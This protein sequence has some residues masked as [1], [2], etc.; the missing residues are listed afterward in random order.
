LPYALLQYCHQ[1]SI[2]RCFHATSNKERIVLIAG[3][4]G[5]PEFFGTIFIKPG[6]PLS[7]GGTNDPAAFMRL[8]SNGLSKNRCPEFSEKLCDFI[9]QELGVL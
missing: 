1:P 5:K 2:G 7:L 9:Y 6:T 3:L 8:K 4:L